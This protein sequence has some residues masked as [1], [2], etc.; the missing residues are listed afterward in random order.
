MSSQQEF[1]YTPISSQRFDSPYYSRPAPSSLSPAGINFPASCRSDVLD[2]QEFRHYAREDY[3]SP[4]SNDTQILRTS[5]E[6][7]YQH[8]E[9]IRFPA[10]LRPVYRQERQL[11]P[12]DCNQYSDYR[13]PSLSEKSDM[14]NRYEDGRTVYASPPTRPERRVDS[15][16]VSQPQTSYQEHHRIQQS[17]QQQR[18]QYNPTSTCTKELHEVP[19][20]LSLRRDASDGD[21]GDAARYIQRQGA[22]GN[23]THSPSS[24]NHQSYTPQYANAVR[25]STLTQKDTAEILL[26][27]I[28][29]ACDAISKIANSKKSLLANG[30]H[31]F[32]VAH[33][34]NIYATLYNAN[35]KLI[36]VKANPSQAILLEQQRLRSEMEALR[37][38]RAQ[39]SNVTVLSRKR[40]RASPGTCQSCGATETPEWR[41]GPEGPR[42]LCNACGLH[43]AKVV[44]KRKA[45]EERQ[46]TVPKRRVSTGQDSSYSGDSSPSSTFS[47]VLPQTPIDRYAGYPLN[48]PKRKAEDEIR[49]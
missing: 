21:V 14:Y 12:R 41:R 45:E 11:D 40:V 39:S 23:P 1:C 38:K 47:P 34:S 37:L 26:D 24:S 19:N 18:E 22:S 31:E 28:L 30:T 15:I 16:P 6:V 3:H 2:V 17:H 5:R 48:I 7:A 29:Y 4:P 10:E 44:K 46:T 9:S 35:Q 20:Q 32:S 25:S 8:R 49:M 42:T 43:F 27:K 33:L 36:S 13:C